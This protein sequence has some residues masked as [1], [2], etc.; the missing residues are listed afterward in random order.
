M[1]VT[2]T[3]QFWEVVGSAFM[4]MRF[5]GAAENSLDVL[6]DSVDRDQQWQGDQIEVADGETA[7][8]YDVRRRD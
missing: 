1:R 2:T 5:G 3:H 6:L 7:F 8:P 4:K